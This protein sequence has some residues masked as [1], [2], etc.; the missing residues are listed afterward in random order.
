MK[1]FY[2]NGK[3]GFCDFNRAGF[4]DADCSEC[5]FCDGTGGEEREIEGDEVKPDGLR[6]EVVIIDELSETD[7]GPFHETVLK[8]ILKE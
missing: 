4:F 8:G 6:A 7:G 2:C 1:G 5:A 3:K